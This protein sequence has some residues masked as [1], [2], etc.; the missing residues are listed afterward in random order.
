[1]AFMNAQQ[2]TAIDVGGSLYALAEPFPALRIW[3]EVNQGARWDA[4]SMSPVGV[5][6]ERQ[7]D[8]FDDAALKGLAPPYRDAV[9]A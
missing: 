4:P 5:R 7:G 8:L 1:M 9:P 6:F 3:R 2:L